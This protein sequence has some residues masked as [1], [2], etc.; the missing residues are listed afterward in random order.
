MMA[1]GQD[2]RSH[3][4]KTM[5]NLNFYRETKSKNLY[6]W[7]DKYLWEFSQQFKKKNSFLHFA[8]LFV[9]FLCSLNYSFSHISPEKEVI[10]RKK[11][12]TKLLM[13]LHSVF[14]WNYVQKKSSQNSMWS[15]EI[16]R[17]MWDNFFTLVCS[18]LGISF[19]PGRSNPNVC[20]PWKWTET[21]IVSTNDTSLSGLFC[22]RY[23]ATCW[24]RNEILV[25]NIWFDG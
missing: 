18:S 8:C 7:C 5:K 10:V 16:D 23:S 22:Y 12:Y 19:L 14:K 17:K 13:G 2:W 20:L 11:T 1:Y 15:S 9:F 24:E 3:R 21:S 6:R 25:K 4:L